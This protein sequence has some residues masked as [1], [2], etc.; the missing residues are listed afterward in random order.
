M[1]RGGKSEAEH[2]AEDVR[3]AEIFTEFLQPHFDGAAF[4]SNVL[5]ASTSTAHVGQLLRL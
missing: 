3:L 2:P 1:G 5:A 4:A